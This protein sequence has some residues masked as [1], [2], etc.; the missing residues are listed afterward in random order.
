MCLCPKIILNLDFLHIHFIAIRKLFLPM[1]I[2]CNII[3]TNSYVFVFLLFHEVNHL[4][5]PKKKMILNFSSITSKNTYKFYFFTKV[6]FCEILQFAFLKKK[7]NC[8]NLR[9]SLDNI[10][11]YP[12]CYLHIYNIFYYKSNR[13]T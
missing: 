4:L 12:V 6:D 3:L 1:D 13:G 2:I 7:L 5:L 10:Y 9:L 11:A 8:S